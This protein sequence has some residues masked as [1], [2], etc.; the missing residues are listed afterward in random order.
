MISLFTRHGQNPHSDECVWVYDNFFPSFFSAYLHDGT[1]ALLPLKG[2]RK[3]F[4]L[5][6]L[7]LG[8]LSS[9]LLLFLAIYV[10]RIVLN[11]AKVILIFISFSCIAQGNCNLL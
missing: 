10:C 2:K 7:R 11:Y 8:S 9:C 4:L 1:F 6:F 5:F 3:V